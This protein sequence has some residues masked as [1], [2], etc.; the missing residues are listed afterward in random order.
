MYRNCGTIRNLEYILIYMD[1]CDSNRNV[2]LSNTDV[3]MKYLE[4]IIYAFL[5]H[6]DYKIVL[7]QLLVGFCAPESV[8]QSIESFR[9]CINWMDCVDNHD[10]LNCAS[11]SMSNQS[12]Q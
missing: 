8:S 2:L 4:T 1:S 6:N 9:F 10:T 11:P 5:F 7:M 12:T 3:L